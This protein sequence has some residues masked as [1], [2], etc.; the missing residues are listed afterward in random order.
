MINTAILNDFELE[1]GGEAWDAKTRQG[2]ITL[3]NIAFLLGLKPVP[4]PKM[5]LWQIRYSSWVLLEIRDTWRT[6]QLI[7]RVGAVDK[8][9]ATWSLGKTKKN[10][11]LGYRL[12]LHAKVVPFPLSSQ[13]LWGT[14]TTLILFHREAK[15]SVAKGLPNVM[16]L[17]SGILR[18]HTQQFP[19]TGQAG[20]FLPSRQPS[21]K[22][23]DPCQ[24]AFAISGYILHWYVAET[25]VTKGEQCGQRQLGTLQFS[26]LLSC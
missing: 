6:T 20:T 10:G 2:K 21:W 5:Y 24:M 8:L 9:T 7:S 3:Q 23:C 22:T 18:A 15:V 4:H 11:L 26:L 19:D 14:N 12:H 16:Q 13:Q 17:L 25:V 1:G